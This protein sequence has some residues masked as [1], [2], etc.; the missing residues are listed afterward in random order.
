[1]NYKIILEDIYHSLKAGEAVFLLGAGVSMNSGLPNA[2]QAKKQILQ[3]L[4]QGISHKDIRNDKRKI[5]TSKMPFELFLQFVLYPLENI[6]SVLDIYHKG[7]PNINHIFISRLWSKGCFDSIYTTNFDCLLEKAVGKEY[8]VH[9][10]EDSFLRI[11]EKQLNIYK[12]HG[13]IDQIDS[14]R[15]TITTI[16]NKVLADKRKSIIHKLFITGK[17][18]YIII[19]G[20]SL[21]D[22][23]DINLVLKGIP[24]GNK[25]IFYIHHSDS[26]K[27]K[28]E[29]FKTRPLLRAFQGKIIY[30]NTDRFIKDLWQKIFTLNEYKKVYK[31]FNSRHIKKRD[32]YN[33]RSN[34]QLG[35]KFFTIGQLLYRG[36]EYSRAYY[37][38][39]LGYENIKH[40]KKYDEKGR[41]LNWISN[42]LQW[43]GKNHEALPYLKKALVNY[44]STGNKNGI[45]QCLVSMGNLYDS[46]GRYHLAIQMYLQGIEAFK[47]IKNEVMIGF[48]YLNICNPYYNLGQYEKMI[49][50][51]KRSLPFLIKAGDKYNEAHGY[52]NL[53]K[54]YWA[55]RNFK[56]AMTYMESAKNIFQLLNDV[57]GLANS[58]MN[59]GCLYLEQKEPEQHIKYQKK[60]MQFFGSIDDPLGLANCNQNLGEGYFRMGHFK[61]AHQYLLSAKKGYEKLFDH[62]GLGCTCR[63]IGD[64]FEKQNNFQQARKF[65]S[66]ALVCFKKTRQEHQINETEKRLNR[67]INI[68]I[69]KD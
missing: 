12:L 38:F 13:S 52:I 9:A 11:S 69:N 57:Q 24:K 40:T 39:R 56:K 31:I 29:D 59:I 64:I 37:Y 33:W 62:S 2:F 43:M 14:I 54:A 25:K 18:K 5:L 17:H 7:E 60:A 55:L 1:M 6:E 3:S 34:I 35:N 23:F 58:L 50:Y 65:W 42:V 21:S 28:L 27:Y 61:R 68:N 19:L 26:P 10:N 67:S 36:N 49:D 32:I 47:K 41:F 30:I 20:Y 44:E 16:S 22:E 48:A 51:Q 46:L 15:T 45:G 66:Q 63:S 4:L 53:G 8:S